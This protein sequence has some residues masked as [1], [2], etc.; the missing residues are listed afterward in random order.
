MLICG[1]FM[2]KLRK[3]VFVAIL[4]T[5][6]LNFSS[7]GLIGLSCTGCI[8]S[9]LLEYQDKTLLDLPDYKDKEMFSCSGIDL[10]A[11]N[12]YYY[13][14]DVDVLEKSDYLEKVEE[15]D[16]LEI[17]AFVK[18]FEKWLHDEVEENYDF[19]N[20]NIEAGD[21]FYIDSQDR[22][23]MRKRFNSYDFYYFDVET[24][25]MYFMHNDL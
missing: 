15:S 7:C 2:V 6:L 23:D 4:L 18:N 21:Y 13:D 20:V 22:Y 14:I 17:K 9:D 5:V 12:R 11:F 25:I 10:T 16:F 24:Q 3:I 1:D 8:V 19:D